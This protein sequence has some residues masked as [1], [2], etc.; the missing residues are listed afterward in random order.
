MQKT[1]VSQ[2]QFIQQVANGEVHFENCRF[3]FDVNLNQT[4]DFPFMFDECEF[5]ESFSCK[6]GTFGK[7][8]SLKDCVF[9][10]SFSCAYAL[11]EKY[12]HIKNN[13]FHG[14]VDMKKTTFYGHVSFYG[15]EFLN[16]TFFDHTFCHGE[17]SFYKTRFASNVY[18]HRAYL[19]NRV[20]FSY[21]AF[22]PLHTVSF[23]SI[24]NTYVR[25]DGTDMVHQPPAFIFRY[26]FFPTKTMFTNVDLS[27][28]LFQDSMI[29]NIVFKNCNFSKKGGR[30]CFYPETAGKTMMSTNQDMFARIANGDDS[31]TIRVN[32]ERR[33]NLQIG[34][35]ITFF[36]SSDPEKQHKVFV[37][38]IHRGR[39]VEHFFDTMNE[40]THGVDVDEYRLRLERHYDAADIETH[41]LIGIS[42]K[43]FDEK[44]FWTNLEDINRQMK[45]SLEDSRDWQEAGDFYRG[46]MHAMINRMRANKEHPVYRKVLSV[47][48]FTTGFCESFGRIAIHMMLS[49]AFSLLVMLAFRPDLSFSQL[50]EYNLGFF[51]PLLG[52]KTVSLSELNL[53][54]WQNVIMMI[55][56]M[57]YYLLWFFLALTLQ[58]KFRR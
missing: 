1:I 33:K 54:P 35:Q 17:A 44:R 29:T 23:F 5:T 27:R 51:I 19:G 43:P 11:F 34:D 7:R 46:E 50:L 21:V 22:S 48:G 9:H 58:R 18:F 57:W 32:D 4:Y 8:F 49:F 47:Y 56:I 2:D 20:D 30:S 12:T 41:G 3:E 25:R 53:P 39:N 24:Q 38:W 6:D 13:A 10:D 37:T 36:D 28:A 15:S 26:I 16:E 40:R 45:R 42:F 14:R 31:M 55:Q 52:G